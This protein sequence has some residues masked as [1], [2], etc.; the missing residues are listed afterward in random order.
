MAPDI[1]VPVSQNLSQNKYF[2]NLIHIASLVIIVS[3]PH[4]HLTHNFTYKYFFS[5]TVSTTAIKFYP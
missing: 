1:S 2:Y 4:P 3:I 5:N